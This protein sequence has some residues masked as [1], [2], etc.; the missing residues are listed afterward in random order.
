M[1]NTA[2]SLNLKSI[3]LKL[4]SPCRGA[5]SHKLALG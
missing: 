1:S 5:V 3:A 2:Y 4:K